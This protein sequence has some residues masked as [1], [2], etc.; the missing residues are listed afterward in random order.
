MLLKTGRINKDHGYYTCLQR[1]NCIFVLP[2]PFLHALTCFL[3]IHWKTDPNPQWVG[4]ISEG[5]H[6]SF[7]AKNPNLCHS[8]S[9]TTDHLKGTRSCRTDSALNKKN[10]FW[11]TKEF[12]F[13][14][15]SHFNRFRDQAGS[16]RFLQI[17][18]PKTAVKLIKVFLHCSYISVK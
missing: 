3:F 4:M 5:F 1:R 15:S 9:S 18:S 13:C 11:Q 6:K 7:L 12:L 17:L 2:S 16:F 8:R 14:S 10:T